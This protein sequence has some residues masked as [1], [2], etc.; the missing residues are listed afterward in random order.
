MTAAEPKSKKSATI[1]ATED[2]EEP[3][4]LCC[5]QRMHVR[6]AATVVGAL[7]LLLVLIMIAIEVTVGVIMLV[8]SVVIISLLF[9]AIH[10]NNAV[11]IIPHLVWQGVQ[12]LILISYLIFHLIAGSMYIV[13]LSGK[14]YEL[15]RELGKDQKEPGATMAGPAAD[16]LTETDYSMAYVLVGFIVF[17]A[18]LALFF[19]LNVWWFFVIRRFYE[20]LKIHGGAAASKVANTG[21]SAA[22]KNSASAVAKN[23]VS[24]AARNSASVAAGKDTQE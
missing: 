14:R 2:F 4:F 6:T 5:C 16:L 1:D 17:L 10:K 8:F 9:W 3:R 11:L 7:E 24:T 12:G 21:A 13:Q 19:G 22:A 20:Y 23:S 15:A 18:Y